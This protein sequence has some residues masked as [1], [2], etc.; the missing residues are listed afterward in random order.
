MNCKYF[1]IG[2]FLLFSGCV[3]PLV[4]VK[5]IYDIPTEKR[6]KFVTLSLLQGELLLSS[7]RTEWSNPEYPFWVWS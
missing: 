4:P 2:F 3:G 7:L 5:K 6:Q 1:L